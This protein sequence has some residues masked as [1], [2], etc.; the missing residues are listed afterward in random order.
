LSKMEEMVTEQRICLIELHAEKFYN[1]VIPYP[2]HIIECIGQHLPPMAIEKNE[3]M[4]KTIR[5]ALKLLD[6]DPKS[7]EEFVQHLALLNKFNNDL[8]NLENEFQIITKLFH[9]I[10]DFNMNIKA[11]SYA[12]YRSLAS[13]YQQLKVDDLLI[14]L[15]IDIKVFI[16]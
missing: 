9:I 5:E 7:V 3:K 16:L 8:T 11:E 14:I 2:K 1:D 6:R 10:K 13:I 12:F 15:I 4:Q